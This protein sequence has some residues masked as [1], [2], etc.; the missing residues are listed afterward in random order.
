MSKLEKMIN[1]KNN[2]F[3]LSN[4]NL[5]KNNIIS[6]STSNKSKI[7]QKIKFPLRTKSNNNKNKLSKIII[8]FFLKINEMDNSI[9]KIRSNLYSIPTFSPKKLFSFLDKNSKSFL[10]LDDFKFFLRDNKISFSEK[11]LRK[12]I[13]NFDKK[14]DFSIN[15]EEFL[16]IISPKKKEVIPDSKEEQ[17]EI[18]TEIQKI[19]G[20]LISQ[21]L[22][23]IEKCLELSEKTN[24][25]AEFSSYE[26]FKEIVGTEKYITIENLKK[27]FT[28]KA[29]K[30]EE[31]E[32]NQLLLR[33]DKDN[34]GV[35]SYEEFK[36][37]FS[38]LNNNEIINNTNRDYNKDFLYQYDIDDENN[39]IKFNKEDLNTK[40][41]N[42]NND[43]NNNNLPLKIEN[44]FHYKENNENDKNK[45]NIS[46]A[47]ERYSF[48]YETDLDNVNN[49]K[50][51]INNRNFLS[52]TEIDNSMSN[53]IYL[54]KENMKN[55]KTEIDNKKEFNRNLLRSKFKSVDNYNYYT[56]SH[57]NYNLLE[58]TKAVLGI[59]HNNIISK[60]KINPDLNNIS[61]NNKNKNMKRKIIEIEYENDYKMETP[62]RKYKNN[63]KYNKEKLN[64]TNSDN[65][66]DS[67]LNYDYSRY[68]NKDRKK[69][70]Y[71]FKEKNKGE[72]QE[73]NNSTNNISKISEDDNN[74]TNN[75]S[76]NKDKDLIWRNKDKNRNSNKRKSFS[77]EYNYENLFSFKDEFN[78]NNK[79]KNNDL[80]KTK[81]NFDYQ[82][83]TFDE[84]K[85]KQKT[86]L[87]F[88][89]GKN[90]NIGNIDFNKSNNN[91]KN[92]NI[93]NK[94]EQK[95][96][97]SL[98]NINQENLESSPLL[99]KNSKNQYHYN[100][101]LTRNL[102]RNNIQSQILNKN[103][104]NSNYSFINR[105]NINNFDK[106]N[107]NIQNRSYFMPSYKEKNDLFNIEAENVSPNVY[108][109]TNNKNNKKI[110]DNN[111]NS[112]RCPKCNCFQS[113]N[114]DMDEYEDNDIDMVNTNN[115][116]KID[117]YENSKNNNSNSSSL[118]KDYY[119]KK[120]NNFLNLDYSMDNA[121]QNINQNPNIIYNRNNARNK[122]SFYYTNNNFRN[123]YRNSFKVK[124]NFNTN[125]SYYYLE[126]S[127]NNN[128][129]KINQINKNIPKS[130]TNKNS[131]IN[132]NSPSNK[133][134][135]LN[136]LFLDF[137]KQDN[138]IEKIRQ[139]LSNREDIN[140]IDLFSLFDN[141][142][143]KLISA[144]NFIQTLNQLGLIIS[145]ED[146]KFLF[147][148]FNKKANDYFDFDE[149]CE[150]IL[151]K[152]HSNEKIM[153]VETKK[154]F[155]GK[156]KR[157]NPNKN[158]LDGIST[159]TKKILALL[160]KNVIEGEKSNENYR[161][162]LVE[163]EEI[164]GFDLFNKIKKNYSV[165]IYKEDI[166]NFMK[167][168]KY[169]LNNNE[170]ELLMDRFDKNKNGMI[171]YKEF[172]IE[173][174]PISKQ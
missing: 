131:N 58:Q 85:F 52:N 14:N 62:N 51:Q 128:N 61:K 155:L 136:N 21:E 159:E 36:D 68:T 146:I 70:P 122:M 29:M 78:Q 127:Y 119:L 46:K 149:F 19:F 80:N 27:F 88:N 79:D 34:D 15:Y 39:D 169:K 2:A 121:N 116:K 166:A 93:D 7:N 63:L 11:N 42:N 82:N 55:T 53:S 112:N 64:K 6:K 140:L 164:S 45:I 145:I 77:L 120:N 151:P 84:A 162:I 49:R 98:E 129:F 66:S 101:K 48:N 124:N 32:M 148:K 152:K 60:I 109:K 105:K 142:R 130:D 97:D 67:I 99:L 47:E 24:R 17:E 3:I 43:K 137:I 26:A 37:I 102:T 134:M 171:E 44:K 153:D 94:N 8:D 87:N 91:T 173:I 96:L 23:F 54:Y 141:S 123:L 33:F 111:C 114:D 4:L 143:K 73:S 65:I 25:F 150:L 144:S 135:A 100:I 160:F 165:G 75:T 76:N 16:G 172:I 41:I 35:I 110:I 13:H 126:S 104:A 174:S 20:E 1:S 163:N 125:N 31:N 5:K 59:S 92:I 106:P 18:S 86:N 89:Y 83:Q 9:E 50:K 157:G 132:K 108:D 118:P 69:G 168:N 156:G 107:Q 40:V 74:K 117:K 71:Y 154:N 56:H 161:K 72:I 10:T 103:V 30:I 170:I 57:S 138:N 95:Y 28:K 133:F 113:E 139:V 38:P 90:N 167:K 81:N 12:L 22:K 147:R 158:L 115:F